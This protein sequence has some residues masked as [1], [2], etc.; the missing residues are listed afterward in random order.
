MENNMKQIQP[1]DL[2]LGNLVNIT[3]PNIVKKCGKN[4]I[5]E[6][7]DI[8]NT[9]TYVI[10][11]SQDNI[12][13]PRYYCPNSTNGM[14][15]QPIKITP[16]MLDRFTNI[17]HLSGDSYMVY[18]NKNEKET[19]LWD[20]LWSMGWNKYQ[21]RWL[22]KDANGWVVARPEYV[23]ELQNIVNI[24]TSGEVKITMK[25]EESDA[26]IIKSSIDAI[27]KMVA[28]IKPEEIWDWETY[29]KWSDMLDKIH[30]MSVETLG[31]LKDS[32]SH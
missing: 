5:G 22:M 12:K 20:Q 13:S 8:L 24:S 15:I 21:K 30:T 26:M 31:K 27:K 3:D 10:Y 19:G 25:Q 9:G 23:H 1:G 14:Q 11:T 32:K 18:D 28:E 7:N 2:M 17:R 4:N 16:E 6:I 29:E